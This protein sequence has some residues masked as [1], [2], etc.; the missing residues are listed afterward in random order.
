M[1]TR[2]DARRAF[3][4]RPRCRGG[5]KG[6]RITPHRCRKPR[7][8]P[9]GPPFPAPVGLCQRCSA[10]ADR[11]CARVRVTRTAMRRQREQSVSTR[12]APRQRFSYRPG[13]AGERGDLG[14]RPRCGFSGCLPRLIG[15]L[16][17]FSPQRG[18]ACDAARGCTRSSAPARSFPRKTGVTPRVFRGKLADNRRS[19]GCKFDWT[20]LA[21]QSSHHRWLSNGCQFS[22]ENWAS[23]WPMVERVA[24][25]N[26]RR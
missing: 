16:L 26:A 14:P 8:P 11:R 3:E 4:V 6:G 19:M 10:L 21:Y 7:I 25:R 22:A 12:L 17:L 23:T 15:D 20:A 9:R 5:A 13:G 2:L 1:P 18:A 24:T